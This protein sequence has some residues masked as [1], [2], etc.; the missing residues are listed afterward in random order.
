VLPSAVNA[1]VNLKDAVNVDPVA[2]KSVLN[3]LPD[4]KELTPKVSTCQV[5]SEFD[6]ELPG[7]SLTVIRIKVAK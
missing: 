4:D 7:N 6:C 1:Q 2:I 5:S 3:G